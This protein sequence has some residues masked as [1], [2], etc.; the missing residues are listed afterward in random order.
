MIGD[1]ISAIRVR[2]RLELAIILAVLVA[3]GVWT[4]F[5]P[6]TYSASSSLL[7]DVSTPDP[8]KDASQQSDDDL[9]G[10]QAD[11]IRSSTIAAAVVDRAQ[12]AQSPQLVEMWRRATG[13]ST[14]FN[15]WMGRRLL[16]NLLLEPVK[17][18]RVLTVTYSSPD[19]NFAALMANTFASTYVDERLQ[20]Q[21]APAKSYAQWF[22]LR[23]REVRKNLE[24]AQ[25]ALAAF[26]RRTGIVDN[27]GF[28]A[29][30]NRLSSLQQQL[31]SAEAAA[32]SVGARSGADASA[33]NDV[34]NSA[35]VSQLRMQIATKSA[36]I[37]QMRAT[38]GP[39]HPQMLAANAE[40]SALNSKLSTEVGNA[41]RTLRETSATATATASDLR[42]KLEAQRGKMLSL[43]ADRSELQGLQNDVASARSAYDAVTQRLLAMRL[44]ST[45]PG[46]NVR[47]LDNAAPPLLPSSP[48]VPLRMFLGLVFGVLLAVGLVALIEYRRPRVRTDEGLELATGVVVLSRLEFHGPDRAAPK[49]IGVST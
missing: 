41:T 36:E 46:T 9:L 31:V 29:E 27:G 7:F 32:A 10:T 3:V 5:T 34:Q 16:N 39:N 11:V 25:S 33:S 19:A 17:G 12:L 23:T 6:K 49:L 8:V 13:G 20:M 15:D 45:V 28:D 43:A 22:E 2:W 14:E 40:L 37:N 24:G 35:L 48:N 4:F 38:L 21:T 26:Q 18:S 44:Q 1:F 47:Q 42:S 30:A